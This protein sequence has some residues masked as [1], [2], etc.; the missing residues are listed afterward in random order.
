MFSNVFEQPQSDPERRV[1]AKGII[2]ALARGAKSHI[3]GALHWE[4]K[5]GSR[6]VAAARSKVA[7]LA[8]SMHLV[9]NLEKLAIAIFAPKSR[10][11]Q[12]NHMFSTVFEPTLEFE[13]QPNGPP[14]VRRGIGEGTTLKGDKRT[15]AASLRSA[16]AFRHSTRQSLKTRKTLEI[17]QEYRNNYR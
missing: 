14:M 17:L 8:M 1:A 2:S 9:E 6:A 13:L 5:E 3:W 7:L 15:A 10:M 12:K 4:S 11:W 16:G